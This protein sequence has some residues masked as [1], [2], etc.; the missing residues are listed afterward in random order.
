MQPIGMIEFDSAQVFISLNV[1]SPETLNPHPSVFP[2]LFTILI[3]RG[4]EDAW[5]GRH[6]RVEGCFNAKCL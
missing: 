4:R 2:L 6:I 3:T 1:F 5:E